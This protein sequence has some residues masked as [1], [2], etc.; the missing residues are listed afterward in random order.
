MNDGLTQCN[1]QH[2]FTRFEAASSVIFQNDLEK[3]SCYCENLFT[4]SKFKLLLK[5]FDDVKEL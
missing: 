1:K 2:K 4:D 3:M 5:S